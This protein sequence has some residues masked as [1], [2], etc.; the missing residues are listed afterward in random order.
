MGFVRR[1]I[2]EDVFRPTGKLGKAGKTSAFA[3]RRHS[4]EATAPIA[5]LHGMG[6]ADRE[7]LSRTWEALLTPP[8]EG[9][10]API[11]RILAE[12]RE[13]GCDCDLPCLQIAVWLS[14]DGEELKGARIFYH[15]AAD[16][17][18]PEREGFTLA[19]FINLRLGVILAPFLAT[20]EE[21]AH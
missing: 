3:F 8:A 16:R 11:A 5:F 12:L 4:V 1:M 15:G 21:T 2:A 13:H 18:P 7:G 19:W 17:S 9:E 14:A 10:P 6:L 20:P